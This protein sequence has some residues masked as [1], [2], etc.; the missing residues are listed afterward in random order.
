MRLLSLSH[1]SLT[2]KRRKS[3]CRY[4]NYRLSCRAHGALTW[5]KISILENKT[6][7]NRHFPTVTNAGGG[8]VRGLRGDMA[9]LIAYMNLVNSPLSVC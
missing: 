3:S 5:K 1:R 8:K 9:L 6:D 7:S 4:G 2:G